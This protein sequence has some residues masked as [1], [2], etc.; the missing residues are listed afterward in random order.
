MD[1][2]LP[3]WLTKVLTRPSPRTQMESSL[4]GIMI[5]MLSSLFITS[6]MVIYNVV[7]GVWFKIFVIAGEIGVLSFQYSLLAT[8][9]QE[10]RN[11]KLQ[12]DMYPKDYKLELAVQKAKIAKE[13]LEK[14]LG[15]KQ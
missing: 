12:N 10:Y 5:M 7:P 6:Y 11:Y 15:D 3:N 9:Y 4:V 13:E 14:L 1:Y 2:I 8:T